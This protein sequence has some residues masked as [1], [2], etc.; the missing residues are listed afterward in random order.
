MSLADI[1]RN[2]IAT[3]RTITLPLHV[4]V[5]HKAWTG[6]DFEGTPTYVSTSRLALVERK[7]KLVR[8]MS[9]T[10]EMSSTRIDF[11]EEVAPTTPTAGFTR[12]N[13]IDVN[14]VFT[15]PDGTTGP[16]MA[17]EGF[18]DGGTGVPFYSTVF[19]G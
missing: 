18:F 12:T 11:I 19:L 13:P 15:L 7:Q 6:Q 14:D 4:I 1:L 8:S 5:T 16:V 3:A 2:G 17:V 9:G 10:E